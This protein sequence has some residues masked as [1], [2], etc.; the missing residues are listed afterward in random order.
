MIPLLGPEIT[1]GLEKSKTADS[2]VRT[3]QRYVVL[4]CAK[5][6]E[7]FW[8]AFPACK[9]PPIIF[10]DIIMYKLNVLACCRLR[11]TFVSGL[12]QGK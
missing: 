2:Y 11:K 6:Q 10:H 5:A 4:R 12:M 8:D 3:L 9:W 1:V 7:G